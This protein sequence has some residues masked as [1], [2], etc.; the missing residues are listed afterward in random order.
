MYHADP[1]L[2]DILDADITVIEGVQ[3]MAGVDP[4]WDEPEAVLCPLCAG[5]GEFMGILGR[6][7]YY[8]CIHCGAEFRA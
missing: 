4:E 2:N 5:D 6:L 1:H 7:T 3:T 8:R